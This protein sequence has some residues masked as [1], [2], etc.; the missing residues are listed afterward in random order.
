MKKHKEKKQEGFLTSE[1]N[2][3]PEGIS[4]TSQKGVPL[5]N[6]ITLLDSKKKKENWLYSHKHLR[7]L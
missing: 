7:V 3:L 4:H 2:L 1:R 5:C 6:E